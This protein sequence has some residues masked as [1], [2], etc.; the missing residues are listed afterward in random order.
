[1]VDGAVH[2]RVKDHLLAVDRLIPWP[3]GNGPVDMPPH[4]PLAHGVWH[5]V[6][7]IQLIFIHKHMVHLCLL[8]VKMLDVIFEKPHLGPI[9]LEKRILALLNY[10]F[11]ILLN[12]N[13]V[14]TRQLFLHLV[15]KFLHV[16]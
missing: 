2:H 7:Q 3:I 4:V 12:L 15:S 16:R 14:D 1:M 5:L 10:A 9:A 13:S 11:V 6:R 8:R